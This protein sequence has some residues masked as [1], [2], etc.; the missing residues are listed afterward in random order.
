LYRGFVTTPGA[1]SENLFGK[2][3][4]HIRMGDQC[5]Q[6]ERDERKEMSELRNSLISL[7]FRRKR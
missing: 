2:C 5:R 3:V 4:T 1:G 7:F 6:R